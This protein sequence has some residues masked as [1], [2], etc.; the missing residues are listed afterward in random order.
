MIYEFKSYFSF[1][2]DL[3]IG[4]IVASLTFLFSVSNSDV[5]PYV[6]L[7]YAALRQMP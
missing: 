6:S 2:C 4:N 5:V 3:I 7:G 1:A